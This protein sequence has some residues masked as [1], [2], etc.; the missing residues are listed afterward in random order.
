VLAGAKSIFGV[1]SDEVETL[2]GTK[3]SERKRHAQQ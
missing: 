3:K 1:D 2:G